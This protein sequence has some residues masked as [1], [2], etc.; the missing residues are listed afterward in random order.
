[1]A[2]KAVA[3]VSVAIFLDSDTSRTGALAGQEESNAPDKR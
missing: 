3:D 1:M 2:G